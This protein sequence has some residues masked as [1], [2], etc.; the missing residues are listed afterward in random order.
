MWRER[1]RKEER[2]REK[3]SKRR[4]GRR[5]KEEE[6]GEQ[7]KK[8]KREREKS[9]QNKRSCHTELTTKSRRLVRSQYWN[10]VLDRASTRNYLHTCNLPHD[11][12]Q[13]QLASPYLLWSLRLAKNK[14]EEFAVGKAAIVEP[15]A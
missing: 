2:E 5:A 8:K 10:R 11:N 14:W 6:G 4:R 12:H 9:Q 15:L 1:E 3:E 7:E 13:V